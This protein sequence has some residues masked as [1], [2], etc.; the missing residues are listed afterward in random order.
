MNFNDKIIHQIEMNRLDGVEYGF[1]VGQLCVLNNK[2]YDEMT[3]VV[4]KF[5]SAGILI[6]NSDNLV[7]IKKKSKVTSTTMPNKKTKKNKGVSPIVSK[8]EEML[9]EADRMLYKDVK[10]GKR[11]SQKIEG[12]LSITAKG[13]GFLLPFVEGMEDVFIAQKNLAGAMHND[14]VLVEV[15]PSSG[16]KTEGKVVQIIERGQNFVVGKIMLSKRVAYVVPDDVKFGKDI[17][18]PISQTL[19]ANQGDK[20]VVTITKYGVGHKKTEGIVTEVLGAPNKIETEVLAIIRS[21]GLFTKFP[22]KVEEFAKTVPQEINQNAVKDRKDYRKELIFTID[23]EDT[24][25]IDDAISIKKL[26]NG[27]YELGVHIAD[28]GEYVP[29]NGI[30]DKEAFHRA[31]SVYFPSLVLPMLPRELSN[32]ICSLNEGV[33]RLALSCVM[34][35]DEK[36]QVV[37]Y[38]IAESVIKSKKRFTYTIV[39]KIL[40]GDQEVCKEYKEFVKPLQ[41]MNELNHIL[42]EA[43]N[44]RGNIE[45]D[46]PEVE[47]SLNDLGDVLEVNKKDRGDAH[48][49]IESFMVVANETVAEHF[50]KN[51][52]PFVYRVHETPS[53]EKMQVFLNLVARVG[54]ETKANASAVHPMDIQ[55]ILSKAKD[56]DAKEMINRVALRSMRK[57]KYSPECLGHFGLASTYYCHFTSPIRRYPDLTIHRIIKDYLRGKL[58]GSVLADTRNFVLASS[59]RSSECEVQAENVERDVDDLYKTFYMQHHLNEVFAG[60]VTS[61]TPFGIFVELENTVEGLV[62]LAEIDDVLEYDEENFMLHGKKRSYTI[63]TKLNVKAVRADILARE[64]DMVIVED[65]MN[66]Q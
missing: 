35:I 43:R 55:K 57:A 26:K 20:V 52:L 33:D 7:A 25:D 3:T 10:K 59:I 22:K 17:L 8:E 11:Q 23:G 47:I 63:G 15:M 61:V 19:D 56:H 42:I 28:V 38:D 31:T 51:N 24:R 34:E 48:K 36:G 37:D 49:L 18:V 32:G 46:L 65:A 16:H 40:D 6:K 21:Y 2:P 60:K 13:Y 4:D 41:T 64:I 12:K 27:H 62:K 14:I 50:K 1:L 54:I 45:F 66:N 29:R 9:L 58:K 5:I 30:L 39:Q 44:R 53:S